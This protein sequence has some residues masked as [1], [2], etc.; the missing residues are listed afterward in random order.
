M[1]ILIA[2]VAVFGIANL[3]LLILLVARPRAAGLGR[4]DLD[5]LERN[6]REDLVAARNDQSLQAKGL[7]DEVG[8]ALERV[9]GS[10]E[11]RLDKLTLDNAAKLEAMRA[12]V[13]EKLQS[14]LDKRLTD[15]FGQVSERLEQVHKG[16]GEM[17]NL[18]AGVGDL[19]RVLTNVKTRGTWGEVQLG[20][21]LEQMFAPEQY[22]HNFAPRPG[23]QDRV[24]YAVRY[25]GAGEGALWLPIDAKFP[26]DDYERL[27]LAAERADPEGVEAAAK[28]LENRVKGFAKEVAEKYIAPP[29]TTDHA[30][31]FLPTEGLYAELLRRPGLAESLQRDYRVILCGP[32][33]LAAILNGILFGFRRIAIAQRTREI[34]DLLGAVKSE[35]GKFGEALERVREKID[36]AGRGMD[37]VATRRRVL[38]KKLRDV[39]SLPGPGTQGLLALAIDANAEDAEGADDGE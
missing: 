31:L 11:Q 4:D 33:T 8:G 32:T 36:Q 38:E 37:Q 19:K 27:V 6:L 3:G 29:R 18:A 34:Q 30:I 16:L 23:S 13:D 10:V 28:A 14:T 9:R 24:E 21:L 20:N 25:P 12:T 2:I 35:F 5:R 15:A 39:E 26:A 1:S 7:R 22:E 17:Q